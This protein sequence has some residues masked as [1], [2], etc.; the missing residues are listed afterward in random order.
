VTLVLPL[1]SLLTQLQVFLDNET[2]IA[3]VHFFIHLCYNKEDKALAL[4]LLFS[5]LDP[6]LLRLLVKTL[7]SCEY[8]GDSA[9]KFIDVK[10]IRTIMAMVPHVPVIGE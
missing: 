8:L 10:C 3:E 4:V 2:Q 6:T 7:W 1:Y 5:N 9:L